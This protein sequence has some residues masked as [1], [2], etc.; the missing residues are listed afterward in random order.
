[1]TSTPVQA[2]VYF[3]MLRAGPLIILLLIASLFVWARATRRVNAD[4][5]N[6]RGIETA[7]PWQF[8][9]SL[10]YALAAVSVLSSLVSLAASDIPRIQ[11]AVT[12]LLSPAMYFWLLGILPPLTALAFASL[13]LLGRTRTPR[14]MR[15]CLLVV[16]AMLLSTVSLFLARR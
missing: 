2:S 5:P 16:A 7:K 6:S 11:N 13:M 9:G 15:V 10:L 1:M 4:E 14:T 12:A 8:N 3:W